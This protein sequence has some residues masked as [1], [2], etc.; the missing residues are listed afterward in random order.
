MLSRFKYFNPHYCS[1]LNKKWGKILPKTTCSKLKNYNGLSSLVYPLSNSCSSV[2]LSVLGQNYVI[3]FWFWFWSKNWSWPLFRGTLLQDSTVITRITIQE[4]RQYKKQQVRAGDSSRKWL[5]VWSKVS[6]LNEFQTPG[7][8]PSL[9]FNSSKNF[10]H[11]TSF[12]REFQ[13]VIEKGK[14]TL[15]VS[16]T[17]SWITIQKVIIFGNCNK[18]VYYFLQKG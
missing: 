18:R 5:N 3:I 1:R 16:G 12:G 9:S 8:A 2:S 17:G 13:R 6:L 4:Y 11:V 14:E 7:K 15:L 10:E